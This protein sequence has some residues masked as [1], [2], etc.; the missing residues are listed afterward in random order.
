MSRQSTG[1][2]GPKGSWLV[3]TIKENWGLMDNCSRVQKYLFN[4]VQ[5]SSVAQSCP[6]LCDP[7]NRSKP[8][9]PVHHHLLEF[10]QTHVHRVSDAIQPS[11]PLASPSPPVPNPSQHQ[12][13]FQWVNSSHEVARVLSFSF[14][15]IPSKEYPG[16]ISFR[17][18]WLD[19]L[20]VQ[21]TL[22]RLLQ[23]HSAKAS[24][25]R[26]TSFFTVH[27]HIHTWP[28]EKP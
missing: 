17:M 18:D 25:L 3:K 12:S 9:L 20:A 26:C 7:M 21:G 28:L 24:I 1:H 22:K 13:L 6:T 19:L 14:S 2:L 10:I 5:F 8:G 4:S 16:L 11:H 23:H 27:S 15:I